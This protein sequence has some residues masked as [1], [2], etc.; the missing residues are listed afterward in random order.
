MLHPL[1]LEK[2]VSLNC[3]KSLKDN[4][5]LPYLNEF[6]TSNLNHF[7]SLDKNLLYV[8]LIFLLHLELN[9]VNVYFHHQYQFLEE[10]LYAFLKELLKKNLKIHYLLLY[11]MPAQYL[12]KL[13]YVLP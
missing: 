2:K 3:L 1:Q 10:N 8:K 11:K 12:L 9:K 13:I 5:L 7:Y 6:D 4:S